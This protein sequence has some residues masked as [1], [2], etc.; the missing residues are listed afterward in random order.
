M[1]IGYISLIILTT[2]GLVGTSLACQR[3]IRQFSDGLLT[4]ERTLRLW[5]VFLAAHLALWILL[6]ALAVC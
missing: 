5:W 2:L 3:V 1:T 6:S 4:Y